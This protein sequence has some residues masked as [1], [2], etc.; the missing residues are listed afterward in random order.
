ML[1][2]GV[3]IIVVTGY[4]VDHYSLIFDKGL[5][6]IVVAVILFPITVCETVMVNNITGHNNMKHSSVKHQIV[7]LNKITPTRI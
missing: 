4:I 7:M 6:H 3:V 2:R 1:D 5:V